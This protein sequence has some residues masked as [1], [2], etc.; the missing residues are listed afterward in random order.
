MTGAT[1]TRGHTISTTSLAYT[2]IGLRT[3][4][5]S[6]GSQLEL[7]SNNTPDTAIGHTPLDALP[8]HYPGDAALTFIGA[9]S[10][11]CCARTPSCSTI[12]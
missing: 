8:L 9:R 7:Y 3:V 4:L 6:L 5:R 12:T 2:L 10:S 11:R 1:P